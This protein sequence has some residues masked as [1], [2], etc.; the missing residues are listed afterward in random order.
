VRPAPPGRPRPR[1]VER[2]ALIVGAGLAGCAAAWALAEQGWRSTLI[3]RQLRPAAEASGNPAGLFHGIVTPQDGLHARWHRGAALMA[4]G[5]IGS[6]IAQ[7]GVRGAV[8]GLLRL[9]SSSAG[10]AG[11]QAQIDA[12]G[13]PA[14]YVRAL[15]AAEASAVAAVTLDRPA[16]FYPGGGWVDPAGYAA[17]LLARAGAAVHWQGGTVV[18]AVCRDGDGWQLLDG[19]GRPIAEAATV[20]LANG[21]DALRL[22]GV[23]DWSLRAIRGQLSVAD[24]AAW[25][26]AGLPLPRCPVANSA[27]LLP[28]IDGKVIFGATADADDDDPTVRDADHRRNLEQLRGWLP[29]PDPAAF[30]Q[31]LQGRTAWRWSTDDRLPLIGAVPLD[32]PPG[33]TTITQPRFV[34][35]RPG[36]FVFTGLGSRGISSCALG[37]QVLAAWVTGGAMP[38]EAG[39]VDAVDPARWRTRAV[40]RASAAPASS[41]SPAQ[42]PGGTV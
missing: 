1:N 26:D 5:L 21:G 17:S 7:H 24:A 23:N 11:M 19:D 14:V 35:R 25:R 2:H 39:L 38:V 15:S 13:L 29:G 30:A 4:Q 36:L 22:L 34:A 6:A 8:D 16:W 42:G 37:A 12:L 40:R 31:P 32:D 9:D 20:V 28:P 3:D 41:E 10:H 27:Y 33:A 18:K